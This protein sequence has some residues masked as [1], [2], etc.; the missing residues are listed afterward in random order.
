MKVKKTFT[1]RL[2]LI[3]LLVLAGG[4]E[5]RAWDTEPDSD[6]KYDK[7]YDRPTHFP[8]WQQPNDWP[9]AEY[10]LV[11]ARLGAKG[12]HLE[13]Y[14]VAVYDQDGK[15]RHCNRSMAKDDHLCVLTIRGTEGDEFHC[16]I[17]YGDF[18]NPT[19]VDATETFGFAT[20][21]IVGSK[22]APFY[23]TA[24]GRTLLSETD[25]DLPEDETGANVTVTR[26]IK[27]GEWGTIC[28]PFAIPASSMSQAFGTQV[29]LGNFT[30]CDVTYEADGET[31]KQITVKFE[32]AT[33]IEANHPYIIKVEDDVTEINVDGVD[34]IALGA[35]E[36]ASVDCDELKVKVGSKYSYYYNSFIG[37]YTNGSVVPK[38]NLFLSGGKFWYSTGKTPMMAFRAYFDFYDVLPEM[39]GAGARIIME[40]DDE[41]TT[42]VGDAMR[43]NDNGQMIND[44]FYDLQGRKVSGQLK[45]GLYIINGKKLQVR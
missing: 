12:P 26:S 44:N 4:I 3:A 36:K 20:N 9:N 1:W 45:K 32:A 22:D 15:L 30:G 31:V 33:A 7:Y 43:L 21:D 17:I 39:E 40:F 42:G 6:G 19:I 14:E 11:C 23:L 18:E 8:D 10:Y 5:A 35:D 24:P 37:N 2:L 25:T 13:N 27:A 34:I 16:Q 41:T 29:Q 28:L 38:Q